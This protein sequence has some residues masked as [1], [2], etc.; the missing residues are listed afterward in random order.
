[1]DVKHSMYKKNKNNEKII[2]HNFHMDTQF[3]YQDFVLLMN[4][5]AKYAKYLIHCIISY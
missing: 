1:M 2:L 5:L 3:Q 4:F